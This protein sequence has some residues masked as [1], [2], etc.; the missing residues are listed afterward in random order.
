MMNTTIIVMLSPDPRSFAAVAS[1]A[2]R[3]LDVA[4][5]AL[6]LLEVG[7]D[8]VRG[9]LG[10][11]GVPQPVAAQDQELLRPIVDRGGDV[12]LSRYVGFILAIA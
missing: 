10:G 8:E 12:W 4:A 6:V 9:L 1:R 2:P 11:D 5:G 3:V 7:V